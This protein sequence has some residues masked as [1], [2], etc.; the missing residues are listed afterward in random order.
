MSPQ[1]KDMWTIGIGME[2]PIFN[3]FRTKN[4]IKE[5]KLRL[6]KLQNQ[7]I[8]LKEGL[9]LQI[10]YLFLQLDKT[11]QQEKS[12]KEAMLAA[13]ENRN[14]LERAYKQDLAETEEV[15]QAQLF[16]SFMTAQYQ[17]VLYDH[18]VAKSNLE[19]VIGKEVEKRFGDQ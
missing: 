2:I 7:Q 9:A 1:N 14:L 13:N 6:S 18:L 15:V 8:L 11:Q 12:A 3:G 17:K 16:E 19:V 4:Q 5:A 10:K